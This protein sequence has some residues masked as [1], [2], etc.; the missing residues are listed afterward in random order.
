MKRCPLCS[1]FAEGGTCYDESCA[2]ANYAWNWYF[3]DIELP[4]NRVWTI[5]N[6]RER[7]AINAAVRP[8]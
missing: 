7:D 5:A 4:C 6:Q 3:R 2:A 1:W 8:D